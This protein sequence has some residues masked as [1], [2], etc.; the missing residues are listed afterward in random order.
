MDGSGG[1]DVVMIGR[2]RRYFSGW[3]ILFHVLLFLSLL[4]APIPALPVSSTEQV[5]DNSVGSDS[6]LPSL[7][8]VSEDVRIG[9]LANRGEEIAHMEWDLTADYLSEKLAPYHFTI[10][11]LSFQEVTPAVQNRSVSF[12]VANPSVYTALE[13]YGLAQRIATLQV[14]GD[15]D[16]IP[17]FGGVICTRSDNADIRTI[18]DLKGKRFA[19]VDPTSL[20][21]WHA[22]FREIQERGLDP[23][24][25]FAELNF[26]GT[27]D[28]A[29]LAVINGY[30]DAGTARSTQLERM[31]KEGRI[32]LNQIRVINDQ[33]QVYPWYP[34]RISTR[35]YPE[36]AFAAVSGTNLTLSMAVS[37]AL[38][39]MDADDPAALAARSA[40]WAIPQDH[41]SVHELLRTLHLPPYEDYRIPTV[42]EVF[43][44]FWLTILAILGGIAILSLLLVNTWH[45]KQELK[46]ALMQ[47]QEQERIMKT[48]ISNLPGVVYRCANDKD[49][50]MMYISDGCRQ[51]TG[52]EPEDFIGNK[53]LSNNDIIHPE[54][55]DDIWDIWQKKLQM[56][57]YF[58]GEYPIITRNGETRWVWERGRGIFGDDGTILFL[59]GFISDITDRKQMDEALK[60]SYQK[61]R[62]LTGLTRHDILN[63]LTSMQLCHDLARDSENM[64]ECM[65]FVDRASAIGKR[66]EATIGFTREYEAFGTAGSGWQQ[67]CKVIES[68][69]TELS[70]GEVIIENLVPSDLTVYADPIIRKVFTTLL[71]NAIRHGRTVTR[72]RFSA[73]EENGSMILICE[74]DGVGIAEEEKTRI[75]QRGYGAHTGIGLFLAREILSITGLDICET[76]TPGE[77]AR[78]EIWVPSGKWRRTGDIRS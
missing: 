40:G 9:V 42:Q 38:L 67:V 46:R 77:G 35:M 21:G 48:L 44:H 4:I 10:I 60:E 28:A 26:T 19:A 69:K 6:H 17:V 14:P 33:S 18:E 71:D 13:Y 61:I 31:A 50:T 43:R 56:N 64:E 75:F 20:G 57:D 22:A 29:V 45:T 52:Y 65:T 34:Y 63:Q 23:E 37:V 5:R 7:S 36:W 32:D 74:D 15:P 78:F 2:R 53:T 59:E 24:R 49:W 47:G 72:I 8:P 12:I 27:H 39:M 66:I 51:L 68:A 3:L 70:P 41:S 11:P 76:G 54:Y 73:R 30:A 58:E 1:E 62:L 55:R 25:D 16:P